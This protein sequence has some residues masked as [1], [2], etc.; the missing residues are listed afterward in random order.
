MSRFGLVQ[1]EPLSTIKIIWRA[2]TTMVERPTTN[3]ATWKEG[4]R[5]GVGLSFW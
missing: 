4:K 5:G 1:T 2:I 3:Q